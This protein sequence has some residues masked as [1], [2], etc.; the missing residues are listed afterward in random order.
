MN[1]LVV[2]AHPDDESLGCGG[3]LKILA[4]RGHHTEVM[5]L[6]GHVSARERR[7]ADDE[8]TA[9]ILRAQEALGVK[10]VRRGDFPN[11][12]MNTVDHLDLVRFI[13]QG[14]RD[15]EADWVFTH[16]PYDLNDDHRQ[17]SVAAQAAA[18]MSQRGNGG[19]P[20]KG[21]A[22][23]EIPS[24]TD[25]QF[26]ST[27]RAFE[28]NAFVEIGGEGL[29]IKKTACE[30]YRHVMRPFPHP[31]SDEV[32]TGMAALRGGQAGARYAEAFQLVHLSLGEFI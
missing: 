17:T 5:F 8:L 4:D 14:M 27:G 23:M 25:W 6:S 21:L 16:H 30:A 22:F 15:S 13:E 7:A 11:I 26:G 3:T 29:A 32:I 28:P 12:R 10:H 18:R 2:V 24:S 1:A 20:L 31:R 19:V 9:D